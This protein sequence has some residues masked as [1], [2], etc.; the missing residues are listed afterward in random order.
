MPGSQRPPPRRGGGDREGIRD[1]GFPART[2]RLDRPRAGFA[3]SGHRAGWACRIP[4]GMA[5]AG[6]NATPVHISI[7][8]TYLGRYDK[9]PRQIIRR[10][11][12]LRPDHSSP[13]LVKPQRNQ[14]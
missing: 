2:W 9:C 3:R 11:G 10:C 12:R 8:R 4:R 5:V 1:S 7:S 13:T 14:G 6:E